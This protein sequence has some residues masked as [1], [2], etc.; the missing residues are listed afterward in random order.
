MGFRLPDIPGAAPPE[1]PRALRPGP[2]YS[3]T[4]GVW[5]RKGRCAFALS[6]GQQGERLVVRAE[7]QQPRPRPRAPGMTGTHPAICCRKA[8]RDDVVG[9]LLVGW[10]PLLTGAP[11]RT[12]GLLGLPLK[13]QPTA[14]EATGL[15]CLPVRVGGRR[16][17]QLHAVVALTGDEQ[18]R[19]HLV[20]IIARSDHVPRW[21]APC[22]LP[23]VVNRL[24]QGDIRCGGRGGGY[25]RHER[26]RV[27]RASRGQLHRVADP[28]RA[29]LLAIAGVG[30]VGGGELLRRGGQRVAGAPAGGS[31]AEALRLGPD[32]AQRLHRRH[33]RQPARVGG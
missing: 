6:C 30:I 31:L 5:G 12:A 33:R 27:W 10:R 9:V 18:R 19:V 32:L 20:H 15:T 16:P 14:V 13:D 2:F 22:A 17:Q 7:R 11:F 3:G 24:G 8:D 1:G 26:G 4:E 23:R 28:G 21:E 25:L 29:A